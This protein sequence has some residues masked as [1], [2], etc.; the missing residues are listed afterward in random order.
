MAIWSLT[1]EKVDKLLADAAQKEEELDNLIKKFKSPK[2]L[3]Q[4]G[5]DTFLEEWHRQLEEEAKRV[6]TLV[7]KKHGG[8]AVKPRK[9]KEGSDNES[10]DFAPTKEKMK[11]PPKKSAADDD[12]DIFAKVAPPRPRPKQKR[13]L[14]PRKHRKNLR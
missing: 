6:D 12:E 13:R 8:K 10:S 2:D 9:K 4:I 1:K 7:K 11:A 14:R 5:L 3:W